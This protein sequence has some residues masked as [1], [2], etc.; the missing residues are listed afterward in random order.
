MK[1]KIYS[2]LLL[3]FLLLL[4]S[5]F[6]L[7]LSSCCDVLI[8]S[9]K[10]Q[11]ESFARSTILRQVLFTR[12]SSLFLSLY[13]P[14]NPKALFW[15]YYSSLQDDVYPM[16][17]ATWMYKQVNKEIAT[18]EDR[19]CH[20]NPRIWHSYDM[21]RNRHLNKQNKKPDEGFSLDFTNAWF[22][23]TFRIQTWF[24]WI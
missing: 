24:R 22:T 7:S 8:I 18:E 13:S 20:R 21:F 4:L 9:E 5:L 2:L 17:I 6:V 1:N 15:I 11:T 14:I 23:L 16:N 3:F 10:K 12:F 19:I